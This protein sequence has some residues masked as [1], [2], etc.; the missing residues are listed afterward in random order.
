[1]TQM[2]CFQGRDRGADIA[3]R[4]VD[5]AGG[6]VGGMNWE[7]RVDVYILLCVKQRVGSCHN[8]QTAPLR[9]L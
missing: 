9:A 7:R 5:T 8:A 6:G 4:H 3:N 2:N 1:M